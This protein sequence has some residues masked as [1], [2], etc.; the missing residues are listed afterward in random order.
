MPKYIPTAGLHNSQPKESG[1]TPA[2]FTTSGNVLSFRSLHNQ[3]IYV[4]GEVRDRLLDLLDDGKELL[5]S[6]GKVRT[7][8]VGNRLSTLLHFSLAKA[9]KLWIQY[10]IPSPVP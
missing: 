8:V 10:K 6:H 4:S 3:G 9:V 7:K 5:T 1:L 2:D